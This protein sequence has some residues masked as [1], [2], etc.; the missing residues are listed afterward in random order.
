L[1]PLSDNELMMKVKSGD[2]ARLG[3]LFERHHKSL[4]G[5][6]YRT[7]QQVEL[8]EDLVQDVFEKILK[9]RIQFQGFGKFTTWMFTIAHNEM[10]DHF[11]KNKRM[12]FSSLDDYPEDRTKSGQSAFDQDE[13]MEEL[14]T[15]ELAFAKL[16]QEKRQLL[17]L[18]KYEGLSYREIGEIMKCS[19]GNARIKVFRALQELRIIYQNIEKQIVI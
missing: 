7:T 6:F 13:K 19:E 17:A 16:G 8:S 14:K 2:I 1:N 12:A 10:A 3:L 11:K 9:K 4:F 15:L 18:C 5:F